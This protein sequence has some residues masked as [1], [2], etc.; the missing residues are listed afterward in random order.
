MA[1]TRSVIWT[2]KSGEEYRYWVHPIATR[3][4]ATPA[5]YIYAKVVARK[6]RVVYIGE[7]GDLSERM[8]DTHDKKDCITRSGAT[9]IHEHISSDDEEER[10]AEEAD[11]IGRYIPPCND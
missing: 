8:L 10:R 5:N 1:Q 11:L 9:R 2:G 4:E 6:W 7:T 3:F